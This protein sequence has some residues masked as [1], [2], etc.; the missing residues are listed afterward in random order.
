VSEPAPSDLDRLLGA[1]VEAS[2]RLL[3]ADGEFYPFALAMTA[4]GDVV[5]PAVEPA[6]DHPAADE[7]AGLLLT[8]LR[9][10]RGDLRAA[11]LCSDVQI[12][13]GDGEVRDAIRVELEAPADDAVVVLV[14]Y[15]G[16]VLEQPFGMAGERRVFR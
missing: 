3:S 5:S 6:S 1:C 11:A 13:G 2:V 10:A 9:E 15:E 4:T 7:V 8:A 16:T 14:P 12:R